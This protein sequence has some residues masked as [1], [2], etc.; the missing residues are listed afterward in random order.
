MI[1]ITFASLNSPPIQGKSYFS[2]F[3]FFFCAY[4]ILFISVRIFKIEFKENSEIVYNKF[5]M[6]TEAKMF[7][8]IFVSVNIKY[9][10]EELDNRWQALYDHVLILDLKKSSLYCGLVLKFA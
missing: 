9:F 10:L 3:A 7:G 5:L 8:Q 2:F 4:H 1:S 6:Q